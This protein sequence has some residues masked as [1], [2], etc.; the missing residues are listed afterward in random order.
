MMKPFGIKKIR[1]LALLGV[2]LLVMLLSV[3]CSD[4]K[5][6]T[7]DPVN[8][9][10]AY[11]TTT[12]SSGS[13]PT[14]GQTQEVGKIDSPIVN[15]PNPTD[16]RRDHTNAPLLDNWHPGWQQSSCF[17]CHTD[18]S[19]I[20]DHSYTDTSLCYLCH[21][22]NGNPGFGDSTPP[23][24][25]GVVAAAVSNGVNLT[26]STD[27]PCI[28][29]LILRTAEGDRLEFPVSVD[30]LTSH[31]YSVSGLLTS[32]TYTYEIIAM[33]KNNN[34]TTTATFGTLSFTTPVTQSGPSTGGSSGSTP[35]GFFSG[36][37]VEA[38]DAYSI[39]V[40]YNTLEDCSSSIRLIRIVDGAFEERIVEGS[41]T[42]TWNVYVP[43]LRPDTEYEV[44][45]VCTTGANKKYTSTKKK[46][47]TPAA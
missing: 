38:E 30:Y 6:S 11:T 31:K 47:K 20:P 36:Y 4:S 46:V 19:R 41:F 28:S 44:W 26:W 21:G 10:A 9:M 45:V 12:G 17:S 24:I 7:G 37:S 35:T 42:S 15:V 29:R 18:Q 27:E 2:V 34:T 3:G 13:L 5:T 32:T 16:G 14:S 23:V 39:R 25:K 43:N 22:T 33:D 1:S 8:P 40:K